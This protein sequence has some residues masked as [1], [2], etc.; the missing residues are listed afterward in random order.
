M[1]LGPNLSQRSK[2]SAA[3]CYSFP[4]DQSPRKYRRLDQTFV[5]ATCVTGLVAASYTP[6]M[7]GLDLPP[8][9][10]RTDPPAYSRKRIFVGT[11]SQSCL[12]AMNPLKKPKYGKLDPS[13]TIKSYLDIGRL[14]NLC[15]LLQWVPGHTDLIGNTEADNLCQQQKQNSS[16]HEQL[17]C[18]IEPASLKTFLCQ[19]EKAFFNNIVTFD[20]NHH[21]GWRFVVCGLKR[22]NLQGRKDCPRALQTLYS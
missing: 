17:H 11:D 12:T 5:A 14:Y 1:G 4:C 10:V 20:R 3:A 19:H 18:K 6:E 22:S 21:T 16:L 7:R 15:F 2:H 8:I 9:I 13:P